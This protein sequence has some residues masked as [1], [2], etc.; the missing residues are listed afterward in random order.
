MTS[1]TSQAVTPPTDE[2]LESLMDE[3][4]EAAGDVD[5]ACCRSFS[6]CDHSKREGA[7]RTALREYVS[8]RVQEARR[9]GEATY[10]DPLGH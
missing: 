2:K 6:E 3:H 4:S 10:L 9:E 8:A 7:A 5:H 1:P